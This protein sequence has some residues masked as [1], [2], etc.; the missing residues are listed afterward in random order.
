M[1]EPQQPFRLGQ[2]AP[3]RPPRRKRTLWP[4][5]VAS[6]VIATIGVGLFVV[7]LVQARTTPVAAKTSPSPVPLS[8]AGF[9]HDPVAAPPTQTYV[10]TG[11]VGTTVT[12][13]ATNGLEI[14]Y[15]VSKVEQKTVDKWG[16]KPDKGVYLLAFL[17]VEVN[18]GEDFICS[19]SISFIG[20]N[21]KVFEE[22]FAEFKGH[23]EFK[24]VDVAAG[25]RADGWIVW[26]V[27]R[28]ALKGGK[29]Q[30]SLD[31]WASDNAYGYWTL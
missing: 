13:T 2:L 18:S 11:P 14:D 7:A 27:P 20:P 8:S 6:G 4:V 5:F 12:A 30:L 19:C 31:N 10:P 21:G 28:S 9:E 26:D 23:D 1:T 16:Q 15:T 17:K 24:S 22:T 29:I 3:P 25:Q